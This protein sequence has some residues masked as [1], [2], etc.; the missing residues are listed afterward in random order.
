MSDSPPPAGWYPD[1]GSP[2]GQRYWDGASWTPHAYPAVSDPHDFGRYTPQAGV[3]TDC[4][5]RRLPQLF[6]DV[7]R[8]LR[9]GWWPITGISLAIWFLWLALAALLIALTVDLPSLVR[10]VTLALDLT[11]QYPDGRWPAGAARTVGAAFSGVPRF[12]SPMP[13]VAAALVVS[14]TGLAATCVQ[15]AAV[16]RVALD[17]AAGQPVTWSA[18][19]RSGAT[20]GARLIGYSL[21]L[22]LVTVVALAAATAAVVGLTMVVPALGVLLAVILVVAWVVAIFWL[23]GR[24][25]PIVVQVDVAS[26]ALRW[27]WAATRRTFWGVLGRYLLWSLVAYVVG[28]AVLTV[29][30]LPLSL[31]TTA[32]A[33][34]PGTGTLLVGLG[35]SVLSLP[36]SMVVAALTYIGVV[37]I[38]R[39]L[40]DDP[41]YRAIA[42]DG[43]LTA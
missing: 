41:R 34:Q 36:L 4:G 3:L 10:A 17:A 7:G 19:W 30:L 2:G 25:V 24:L 35:V 5:M 38:W 16:N 37:P 15:V 18:G 32:A 43:S 33:L 28:Q 14:G 20:G 12:D 13:Y 23:L 9:R 31:I 22:L 27:T 40:T 11:Q 6:D 21:L 1:P 8:I 39:D 29:A 42:P 26:G